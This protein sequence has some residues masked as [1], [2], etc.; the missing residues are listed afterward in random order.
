MPQENKQK[1]RNLPRIIFNASPNLERAIN[2]IAE[3]VEKIQGAKPIKVGKGLLID[4][5]ESTTTIRMGANASPPARFYPFKLYP[6]GGPQDKLKIRVYYGTIDGNVPKIEVSTDNKIA[7]H[8][9]SDTSIGLPFVEAGEDVGEYVIYLAFTPNDPCTTEN[10]V[11][12]TAPEIKITTKPKTTA[13][14]NSRG[15]G[16]DQVPEDTNVLG[17]VEIGRV[18]VVE[19]N[20][21]AVISKIHQSVTHS[22]KHKSC[23]VSHFFWGV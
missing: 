2:E 19:V 7:I 21:T 10:E 1:Y 16:E 17:H 20:Q 8:D 5:D 9:D 15:T 3:A 12:A 6:F 22:L 14:D 4:D 13:G 18:T 23:G 11:V